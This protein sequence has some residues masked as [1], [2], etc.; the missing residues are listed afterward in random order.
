MRDLDQPLLVCED[1]SKSYGR[2]LACRNVSFELYPGEV[3]AIVGEFRL[4]QIDAA[5]NAV[6]A[7][8]AEQRP[9]VVSH[10]RRRHA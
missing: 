1:L 8:A 4:G 10:A 9:R 3:L 5:A 2:Q 6:D 7:V